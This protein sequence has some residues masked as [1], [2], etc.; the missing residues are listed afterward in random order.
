[1]YF[2]DFI[3]LFSSLGDNK[4]GEQIGVSPAEGAV[5]FLAGEPILFCKIKK[6]FTATGGF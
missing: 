4:E 2:F 5:R 3:L 6:D 1:M